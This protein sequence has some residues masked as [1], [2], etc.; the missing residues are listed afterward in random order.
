MNWFQAIRDYLIEVLGRVSALQ[1][2]VRELQIAQTGCCNSLNNKLDAQAKKLE[3]ILNILSPPPP[4]EF[5]ATITLEGDLLMA[6]SAK[7]TADL[8]VADNGTF[9]VSLFF[10]D[11]AGVQTPVPA[12]LAA[13]YTASDATPGPSALVLT[14]S[15]D[16]S[17]C[18][19]SVNQT[20]VQAD[21]A[22]GT[23]LPTGLSVSV[24]ATWTGLAA[25]L[26]VVASPL[27]DI[28]AGPANSFVATDST[29]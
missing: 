19:G 2:Q 6:K 3:Q 8:Q 16:T 4:V 28:V 21:S 22:A 5:T 12:G 11:A 27:I 20:T 15:A 24:T 17:S 9:T 25:P 14:P 7:A 23:P 18:A 1:R 13:T 26:T 29:P 10:L